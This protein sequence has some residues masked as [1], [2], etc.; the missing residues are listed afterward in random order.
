[1]QIGVNQTMVP[2]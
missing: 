2:Y 1:M